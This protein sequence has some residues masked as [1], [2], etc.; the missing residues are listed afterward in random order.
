MESNMLKPSEICDAAIGAGCTKANLRFSQ[1]AILGTLA[2]AFIA[3]GGVVSAVVSHSITNVGLAKFAGGAVFPVG[4]ILVVI[5]GAELFTGNCLMAVPL[6]GKEINIGPMLKNWAVVYVFNFVGSVLIAFLVFEAGVFGLSSGKLGGT[7][8][9][10][11][12]MKASLPFWTAFC[13]GIMC[14][15]L[16]CLA[17]WGAFAAKDI[18]SKIVII[19][20]PIM[21]FVTCG[22]EHCV[23]N[24]YFLMAGI[25]AK[26]NPSFVLAS[27]LSQDKIINGMGVVHNLI[28][29]T[30]GNIV[31]GVVLVAMSYFMAYKYRSPKEKNIAY[32]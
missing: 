15:F 8:I 13:S 12:S 21:T 5:C 7:V 19:W 2:G 25:F 18:V 30:L 11:A 16:V 9:K 10:A 31:G 14:N 23:A 27:G 3:V 1:E 20:F 24:M 22:F 32:K 28:P 17:V 26:S 4:L 29:V 6:A